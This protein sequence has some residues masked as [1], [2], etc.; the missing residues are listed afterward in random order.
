M[1][2]K[3]VKRSRQKTRGQAM[4]IVALA[5]FVL[6]GLVGFAVDGGSM[7][8]QRRG[9]QNATDGA[10][11]A[12]TSTMLNTYQGM[13]YDNGGVVGNGDAATEDAILDSITEYA[14]ANGVVAG[15]V[16]AYFVNDS[17]Q[18]VSASTGYDSN[19]NVI[20]GTGAGQA[21][22]KVGENG[23]V[24][25]SKGVKGIT[26]SGTAQTSAFFMSLFGY[27]TIS[28]QA[29]ATAFMGPS[30]STGPDVTLLPIGF[31]TSTER[32]KQMRV[33]Q[34]YTLISGNLRKIPTPLDPGMEW[35]V[36]GNWGYIDFND[37]GG[38]TTVNKAWITCG[39]NPK[40]LDTAAWQAFCTDSQYSKVDKAIG[41]TKYWTGAGST[42]DAGPFT[43]PRVEWKGVDG[44]GPD[45]WL[46]GST[47]VSS[48]CRYFQE[49]VEDFGEAVYYV[50]VF[51]KWDGTGSNTY[52]HLLT[53]ASFRFDSNFNC[54][55][56]RQ[57]WSIDAY[58]ETAYAA[59]S[60]GTHGD[61]V[62]GGPAAVFLEP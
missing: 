26:V 42:W 22:C 36:S 6:I 35:D 29:S 10:A 60:S 17:K 43:A 45:W 15:T 25:W 55:S 31:Y 40:A 4:V 53:I 24:P 38:S 50:P 37:N 8:L 21:A 12:G 47:G 56:P 57:E 27:N 44:L 3:R 11:L 28:A 46:K 18:V 41:P 62:H 59:G 51:D 61:L 1:D 30:L 9:A 14:T 23:Y 33:G 32:L 16:N 58:F 20:C 54:Q 52:F 39:Y 49:L 34:K 5:M 48:S 2:N 13:L 7:Y 19:G